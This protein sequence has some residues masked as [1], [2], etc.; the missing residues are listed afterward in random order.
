M[1]QDAEKQLLGYSKS[2]R[3]APLSALRGKVKS[4]KRKRTHP[5]GANDDGAGQSEHVSTE[6]AAT[7]SAADPHPAP[8]L[9]TLAPVSI[10]VHPGVPATAASGAVAPPPTVGTAGIAPAPVP[11]IDAAADVDALV[12][13]GLVAAGG[14]TNAILVALHL[15]A[16]V[17]FLARNQNRM[18]PDRSTLLCRHMGAFATMWNG[19]VQQRRLSEGH[20]LRLV[21]GESDGDT[22]FFA[23]VSS[24]KRGPPA[25]TPCCPSHRSFT[26]PPP[27]PPPPPPDCCRLAGVVGHNPQRRRRRYSKMD[28]RN[29]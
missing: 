26:P 8:H 29:F 24:N 28:A 7:A 21:T 12:S 14:G 3:S 22:P 18:L 16:K 6:T 20:L 9:E 5:Q 2:F 25:R 27:P 10:R 1:P 19:A 11:D 4:S 15:R 13:A 23:K 17:G